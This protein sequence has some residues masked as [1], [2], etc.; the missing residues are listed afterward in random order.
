MKP[1]YNQSVTRFT[2]FMVLAFACTPGYFLAQQNDEL[3]FNYDNQFLRNP[4][5][6]SV[7][8]TL[9]AGL[10]YQQNF[11][12]ISSP[13]VNMFAG[14]Q[15]P[16]P[17]QNF[18]VGGAI[19]TENAGVLRHL[20]LNL[21]TSYK[22][23]DV[24]NSTDYLAL[25]VGVNFSELG[26]RGQ[27]IIATDPGDPLVAD[28]F[29]KAK[30]INVGF[31]MYYNS[32]RV[33]DERDPRAGI[34]FGISGM[35]A[36]PQTINLPTLSYKEN[37]YLYGMMAGRL[38]LMDGLV[39][40]PMV[41]VQY[42]NRNLLNAIASVQMVYADALVIGASFD[43]FNTLG[44]QFGYSFNN[45]SPGTSSYQI[46]VNTTIPLGQIDQYINNGFGIGFQYRMWDNQF[47]KF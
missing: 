30:S 14:I 35:K 19:Y 3:R 8:N 42:E 16:V 37:L 7:W 15:Y 12:A 40:R 18:A 1:F 29:E 31:G 34:Q 33:I 6:V 43:K 24:L 27:D 22:L 25:G 4:A 46:T 20:H 41:E 26:V 9:D 39:L 32:M 13:P 38:P 5:M 47:S 17:Y 28:D 21:S 45:L 2:F 36:V 44:F 11:S 23:L 10:Y